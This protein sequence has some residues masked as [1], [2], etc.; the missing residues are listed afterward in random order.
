MSANPSLPTRVVHPD[1]AGNTPVP[2]T[3][4]QRKLGATAYAVWSDM[5]LHRSP[6]GGIF[7]GTLD[8]IA[9]RIGKTARTIR[10][11]MNRRLLPSGI[12]QDHGR[13]HIN[14]LRGK[15]WVEQRVRVRVVRGAFTSETMAMVPLEVGDWLDQARGHGGRRWDGIDKSTATLDRRQTRESTATL[16]RRSL[17]G[18]S[19]AY[20][21]QYPSP[22]TDSALLGS[23][24][25]VV[26][27]RAGSSVA[28]D[29]TLSFKS[30]AERL[31]KQPC[32]QASGTAH[33]PDSSLK[34][35]RTLSADKLRTQLGRPREKVNAPLVFGG[36]VPPYPGPSLVK[37]PTKPRPPLM[38]RDLTDPERVR[39]L[40]KSYN[41]AITARLGVKSFTHARGDITKAKPYRSLVAVAAML[42]EKKISP[43]GWCA[44]RLDDHERLGRTNRPPITVIFAAKLVNS[45]ALRNIYRKASSKYGGK[46]FM[47]ESLRTLLVR[48][49]HLQEQ[50]HQTLIEDENEL[51]V[52][53][54]EH[55]P[56]GDWG[57]LLAAAQKDVQAEHDKYQ[58]ALTSG[59]FIW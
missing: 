59:E 53:V 44:W 14:V 28:P 29:K 4:L 19:V 20:V 10:A 58:S 49:R 21:L 22:D 7:H 31:L 52:I 37:T 11:A 3:E 6:D 27:G 32:G 43:W 50:I 1:V 2:V 41:A 56:P 54:A 26:A 46:S 36:V 5:V 55:F 18:S 57:I 38:P 39:I 34:M 47:P 51:A 17:R 42:V 40:V 30:C 45:Q 9:K 15:Q 33:A 25:A 48:Y 16:D 12:V 13:K 24:V 8:N 23:S 35:L